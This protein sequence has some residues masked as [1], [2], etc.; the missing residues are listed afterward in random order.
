MKTASPVLTP[1]A[2][3]LSKEVKQTME[4]IVALVSWYR[5]LLLDRV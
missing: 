1:P 3:R 2:N 4:T 5:V